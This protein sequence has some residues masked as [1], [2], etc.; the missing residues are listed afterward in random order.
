[1]AATS[2]KGPELNDISRIISY[3][4]CAETLKHL[5]KLLL[6]NFLVHRKKSYSNITHYV[7]N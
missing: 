4:L 1:M 2:K 6:S 7:F 3:S 5:L